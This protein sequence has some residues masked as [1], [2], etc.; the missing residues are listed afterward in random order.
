MEKQALCAL[1]LAAVLAACGNDFIP[2]SKLD[3]LRVLA[4]AAEPAMPLPGQPTTVSALVFAPAGG[5]PSY[6]W[7]W[8]PA[9]A[10]ASR[11]YEC[12]LDPALAAQLFT[13]FLDPAVPALPPPDLGHDPTATLTNPFS[14][15]A[16]AVL[17][18]TGLAGPGYAQSF[19]CDD[20][21]PITLVLDVATAT[22][23]LRA[24]FVV[25]LPVGA[26]PELNLNPVPL[27]LALAGVP[28][29]EPAAR[30][31]AAPGQELELRAD[32]PPSA[33]ELRSIPAYEGPPGQ[34]LER[35]TASWFANVGELDADRTAFIEGKT[36]LADASANRWT[37]PAAADWPVDGRVEFVVVLRD[38]R[39]GV[40]WLVRHA[41]LE[42][43]P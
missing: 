16:L 28:L 30:I 12:A 26:A 41:I 6:H 42:Q 43:A 25:R 13:P 32:I 2:Y 19:D 40:G 38:D 18:A 35:L 1:G 22:E 15:S 11:Q 39:G 14:P 10:L 34:R 37:A 21:F 36:S 5:S 24:G 9:E 8:C 33:L 29:D 23:S 7:T 20:G 17:C 27:G 31:L 4:V 3:R